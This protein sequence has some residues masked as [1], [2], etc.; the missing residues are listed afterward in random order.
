MF[1]DLLLQKQFATDLARHEITVAF[2]KDNEH[3]GLASLREG[4]QEVCKDPH[5][6]PKQ[7]QEKIA[8]RPVLTAEQWRD[9][10]TSKGAPAVLECFWRYV[11]GL[12]PAKRLRLYQWITGT[13]AVGTDKIKRTKINVVNS[14]DPSL[15]PVAHTCFTRLDLPPYKDFDTLS[16]KLDIAAAEFGFG[17][18]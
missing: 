12:T 4:F 15:L 13:R 6:D 3:A 9:A 8:G 1:A 18:A 7:L 16:N 5:M 11:A 2:G 17:I 10:A 14:I